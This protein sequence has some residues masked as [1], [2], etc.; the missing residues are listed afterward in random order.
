MSDSLG[1]RLLLLEGERDFRC[2]GLLL[3]ERDLTHIG[4][5]GGDDEDDF[6]LIGEWELLE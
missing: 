4:L 5:F 3:P 6:L 1:D 2:R